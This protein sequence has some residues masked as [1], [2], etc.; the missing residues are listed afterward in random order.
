MRF[1]LCRPLTIAMLAVAGLVM[2]SCQKGNKEVAVQPPLAGKIKRFAPTEITADI[3]RLSTGDQ[4][5][6]M[7]LIDAG[8]VMDRIYREQVWSGNQALFEKLRGDKTPEGQER[9]HYFKINFGP[10]SALDHDQPFIDGVP[11]EKP[12]GANFYP[13]GMT[14]DE[15]EKWA[16][17]LSPEDQKKARGFF[18]VIR[19]DENRNLKIVPYSQ[20]YRPQL[21]K[22]AGLLREAAALTDNASLKKYLTLRADAFLKDDYYDSDVAWMELDAPLD[23]T[24]GPYETYDDELFNYKASF[25]GFITLRDDEE[26]RKLSQYGSY[27]QELENHLPIDDKYKN[28]KLGGLAPLRV[29]NQVFVGGS[30]KAGVQTAAFNLPNDEK[31]VKEKG[32]KRVML[33]NVQEAK[34][35]SALVPISQT[36]LDQA[37]LGDLAF[38]PFFTHIVAHELMHGLGPH[39][40]KIGGRDSTVRQQLKELYSPVEEAKADIT[41]LWALQYLMDQGK[42][43]KSMERKL[44]T[45]F[46][47]SMFRSVRFGLNEAHG[48]G[49]AL[50]FNYLMDEGAFEHDAAA[51][52]YRV[53]FEKVKAAVTKLT[54]ELLTVEAEGSYDKAKALLDKYGVI[55]PYL[56]ATLD[57]LKDVPTDIEPVFPLAKRQD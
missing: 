5:A 49:V 24:I 15:F 22:T 55:R 14:K 52:T 1:V 3:S 35:K 46:L 30:S 44:Y 51:G 7:K 56:Q 37:A 17:A 48:K 20:Q 42:I 41:G 8:K 33:R 54:R 23:I 29:V 13:E 45:T 57:K 28:P 26:T 53:N 36:I 31:V 19:R 6:L 27:L 50:Q 4:R 12:K 40:I 25:E 38:D 21:E 34:F 16:A 9:L 39:N 11:A 18:W 47:A 43:D 2:M 32:S 10:W